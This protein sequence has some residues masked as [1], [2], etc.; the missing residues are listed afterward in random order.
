VIFLPVFPVAPMSAMKL[1]CMR[2]ADLFA[3]P[4]YARPNVSRRVAEAISGNA[5]QIALFG[6]PQTLR[7]K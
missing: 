2:L 5:T 3:Y 4:N 6:I 1:V 7:E